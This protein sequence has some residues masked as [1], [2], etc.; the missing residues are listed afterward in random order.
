VRFNLFTID[1]SFKKNFILAEIKTSLEELH[2]D[3][4]EYAFYLYKD[5][6]KTE[7]KWYSKQPF[8]MFNVKDDSSVY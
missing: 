8:C 3:E 6:I 4:L 5:N 7:T 2:K 1:I